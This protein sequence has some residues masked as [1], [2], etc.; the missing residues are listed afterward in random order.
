M[1][2]ITEKLTTKCYLYGSIE[3]K[4]KSGARE[5][6]DL[7]NIAVQAMK[8]LTYARNANVRPCMRFEAFKVYL[9]VL[10]RTIFIIME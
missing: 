8:A 9:Y 10:H 2:K 3:V 5:D 1:P 6:L 7:G 4:R